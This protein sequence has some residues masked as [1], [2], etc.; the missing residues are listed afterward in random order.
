MP[1]VQNVQLNAGCGWCK[2]LR[3]S[4]CTFGSV[5][6]LKICSKQELH[7]EASQTSQETKGVAGKVRVAKSREHQLRQDGMTSNRAGKAAVAAVAGVKTKQQKKR[8]K[9][10]NK[11]AAS[12]CV[13]SSIDTRQQFDLFRRKTLYKLMLIKQCS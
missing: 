2:S 10:P 1:A 12:C 5:Q 7:R 3:A 11:Y 4:S 8:K 9:S 6:G 13:L